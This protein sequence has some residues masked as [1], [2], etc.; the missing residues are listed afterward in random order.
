MI[1]VF[2]SS[3]QHMDPESAKKIDAFLVELKK[4]LEVET[5]YT[6][7]MDDISGNSF[8]ENIYAP[9]T[10]PNMKTELYERTT[11]QDNQL[12]F[13]E[14]TTVEEEEAEEKKEAEEKGNNVSSMLHTYLILI[15][16][17]QYN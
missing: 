8:I 14:K 9:K 17:E 10:D 3:F 5:P 2:F 11:K 7:I 6:V 15:G 16:R 12:G 13:Y 1:S 4:C